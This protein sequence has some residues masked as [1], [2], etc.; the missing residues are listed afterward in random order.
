[1][2][3]FFGEVIHRYTRAQA[4]ED[5]VLVDVSETAREAGFGLP[6]AL[7]SAVWADV[8]AQGERE[9]RLW[10]VLYVAYVTAHRFRHDSERVYRLRMP[11]GRKKL[12]EA[13]L[14]VGPGDRGEPVVTIMLP[15]ES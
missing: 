5:G 15:D 3:D 4:I 8:N 1:M 7:T 11:V 13:K 9:G 14:H 6:V 2:E 12:Y 10:D